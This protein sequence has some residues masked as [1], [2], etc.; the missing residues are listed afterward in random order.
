MLKKAAYHILRFCR[1]SVCLT[2]GHEPAQQSRAE[3]PFIYCVRCG[4]I[5][6]A[7]YTTDGGHLAP[8]AG[9]TD[10]DLRDY[11]RDMKV[12]NRSFPPGQ[13]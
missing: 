9:M 4:A 2:L 3:P 13:P 12:T 10:E 5:L 6:A 11:E 7:Y 8:Y 1:R